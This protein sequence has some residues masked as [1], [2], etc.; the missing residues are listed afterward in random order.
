MKRHQIIILLSMI[1]LSFLAPGKA[2][3]IVKVKPKKPAVTL[4]KPAKP[5]VGYVWI[6]GHW[7]VKNNRY[8]WKK[9]RWVKA[10][11]KHRWVNGHW[12][13][14]AGAWIWVPG[15]WRKVI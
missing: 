5:G 12:K 2:Q 14:T 15:H 8:V 10:R 7:V 11:K 1:M 3:I 4:I 13:R 9:G 6:D